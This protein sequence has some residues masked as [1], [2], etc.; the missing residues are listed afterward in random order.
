MIEMGM[1]YENVIR[2]ID[3][4]GRQMIDQT[5]WTVKPTVVKDPETCDG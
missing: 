4:I 1:I 5:V 3:L 2:T